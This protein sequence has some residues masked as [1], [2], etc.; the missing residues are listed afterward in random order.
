M[1]ISDW[2]SDVCSSDLPLLHRAVGGGP[3][4]CEWHSCL[5]NH[6][7]GAPQRLPARCRRGPRALRPRLLIIV[8]LILLGLVVLLREREP[9]DG[10]GSIAPAE[11]PLVR[12]ARGYG[13]QA[14]VLCASKAV[15][16][17]PLTQAWAAAARHP[18]AALPVPHLPLAAAPWAAA[19]D[20]KSTR[21][22]S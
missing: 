4:R 19:T 20:R 13:Q 11:Q 6:P 1:R 7:A 10:A 15:A 12:P 18:A 8:T 9:A 5:R 22:N 17:V 14:Q 21:L 16:I 3:D 2:S